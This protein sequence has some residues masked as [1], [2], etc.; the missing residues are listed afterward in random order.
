MVS[1]TDISYLHLIRN[2][3]RSH[4]KRATCYFKEGDR[5]LDIAPQ[6][7]K[8]AKEF[9]REVRTFDLEVGADYQADIC[10]NNSGIIPDASF[11]I[12]ICTE[13]LEHVANPFDAVKELG[14]MLKNGGYLFATTP[15]NFRIHGPL[16]DNWRFTIHGLRELFNGWETEIDEVES[17]RYLM[18]VH[19]RVVAKKV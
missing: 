13:V 15:F 18:P 4:I 12:I 11:D 2:S 16:P 17:D 6:V 10:K 19:Y 8:G 14:R 1:E 7:H 5:V 9:F 3:V